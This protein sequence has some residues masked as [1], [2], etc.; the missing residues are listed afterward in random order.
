MILGQCA[1]HA[2]IAISSLSHIGV[3]TSHNTDQSFIT[4]SVCCHTNVRV[5]CV[6]LTCVLLKVFVFSLCST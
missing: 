5:P 3:I 1:N 4:T 2:N 6:L